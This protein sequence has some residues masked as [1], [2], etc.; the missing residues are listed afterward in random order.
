MGAPKVVV[1]GLDGMT[2]ELV[3][4]WMREG[5]LPNLAAVAQSGAYGR[6][7]STIPPSSPQA[8]SSALTGKNPGKHGIFGFVHRGE[9]SYTPRL[10]T[11]RDRTGPDLGQMVSHHGKGCGFLFVPLTYPPYPVNGFVVSGMG[12]P[13]PKSE[14][15]YP[16]ELKGDLLG[17]FDATQLFEPSIVD[18]EPAEYFGELEDS[19]ENNYAVFEWLQ[20]EYGD[21]DCY[22]VV[23]MAPDRIQHFAWHFMESGSSR[24]SDALSAELGQSILTVYRRIDAVVG[25]IASNLHS[26]TTLIL[27][28]D[29]G[30][31]PYRKFVDLNAW[32][33]RQ[34]FLAFSE[35]PRRASDRLFAGAY[36]LWGRG[37]RKLFSAWQRRYLKD[38]L[39]GGLKTRINAEWSGPR[40]T[41]VDWANTRAF[42]EGTEGVISLNLRGREPE[43]VVRLEER[44]QVLAEIESGLHRLTDP[45]TGQPVVGRVLRKEQVYHG[46]A[47]EKA[48][49]LI[50][51]WSEE[52]YHSR[53]LWG[54]RG[55]V[56]LDPSKW[57]STRMVLSGHH[58]R[59]GVILATGPFVSPGTSIKEAEIVDLAPT[60][61]AIL[62]LPLLP[63]FDG[64]MLGEL[65]VG[66]EST[67]LKEGGLGAPCGR[68]A[69]V[70]SEGETSQVEDLLRGLGYIE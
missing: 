26:D 64:R 25:R 61:L 43:G 30:G 33:A 46:Q 23:F 51:Q 5:K 1:I 55:A 12:T 7:L 47:L 35:E 56:V 40:M 69:E 21:L 17:K 63:D 38:W 2:P 18:K 6:L 8:W 70:Y 34:G 58:R 4:R 14:F 27:M 24:A 39:P 41:H 29:H 62:G 59:E 13:G 54:P 16:E 31:G 42:S 48:P 15:T 45:E 57:K 44:D 60:I 32:L 28:S 52:Q 50:I 3:E 36:R 65:T 10:T 49:D 11:S 68:D 37:P 19:V 20:A 9:D 53:A 22:M 67:T 66:L